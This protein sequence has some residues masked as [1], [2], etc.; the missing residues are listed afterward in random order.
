MTRMFG[1]LRCASATEQLKHRRL[2]MMV[3]TASIRGSVL[4]R[5]HAAR[6]SAFVDKME[7]LLAAATPEL[8]FKTFRD[9]LLVVRN[10]CLSEFIA[11]A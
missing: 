10:S 3:V 6:L 9:L 1:G 5:Y 11:L 8:G 4:H 2:T 7:V